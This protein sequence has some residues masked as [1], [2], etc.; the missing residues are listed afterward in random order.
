MT[1][2]TGKSFIGALLAKALHDHTESRILVMC[3]TNHA[4][5]QF[6]EDLLDI[7]IDP[8]A[9]VRLGSKS[10]QRTE[11]LGLFKQ[12]S[13]FSRSTTT[14]N[15]INA[16]ESDGDDHID[17][18]NSAF[19]VYRNLTADAT[20]ILD[21]LE[22][23][24]PEYFEAFVVPEDQNGMAIV[25]KKGKVIGKDYLYDRW[26]KGKTPGVCSHLVPPHCQG[27]W[28]LD[29]KARDQKN[30]SWKQGLLREQAESLGVRMMLLDKCSKRLSTIWGE[31]NREI[32]KTK[33]IIGCTTTAA[34]MYSE[35]IRHA[36]PEIVLLEEAGEILESHVLTAMGPETK[37]LILIGDHQQLR[38]KINGYGLSVEKGDGYDL[39]VSLFERLINAGF[40]HTTLLK[41]H[42]MCP[43]I[44]GLVRSLTYPALE[45]AEKT[46]N[47]PEPRGLCDRVIF[48][49]HKNFEAIFK[50]VSDQRDEGSKGSKRN[51]FEAEIVLKIVKYLGQQG[52]GTDKLV[53]LTPYLGQL[54]LLKETLSKQND[55]VL[56]D[57]DSYDLLKA[58]LLSQASAKHSKRQLKLS[59]IDN[60]QGEESEIVIASLTRSNKE[61]DIGFMAAPERL[62]VLLSRARNVLI[63]VGNS[64]TFVSSRKGRNTWKPLIDQLK[65]DGHLYDGLPVRCEQ[66]PQT[67]NIL[68]TAVDFDK[69]CPEG[70]CS[71]PCDVT[72]KC[73]VHK[74][75]SRC[76]QLVDHSQMPCTK[77]VK[78][79]CPRGH[80]SSLPCSQSKGHCRFCIQEDAVKER[81]R[82]RDLKLETERQRKQERY[83]QQIAEAQDEASHLRRLRKDESDD[84]ER[85]RVLEQHHQEIEDLKA[86]RKTPDMVKIPKGEES[87]ASTSSSFI[88][89]TNDRPTADN[90]DTK[91]HIAKSDK[92]PVMPKQ[93]NSPANDDWNDQ[94]K[95]QN[96]QSQEIDKLME[97]IG[98]ESVKDK[99]L[100]IKFKVETAIRQNRSLN[101]ER[102]GSVLLGN[103]GTGKTTVARLYAKFLASMGVIPGDNFIETSGSR[104]AN[105]GVS[106]CQ[107]TIESLLKGGGGAFF[108]DEAYQLVQ[109]SSLGGPQVLDFLLA[110][111]EKLRGKIV[112]ILAGY[113]RPMEKF[114]AHNPGLPERFPHELKFDDFDDTELMQILVNCIEKSYKQKMNVEGGLGGLYC[115]IVARRIG[116]GR[117]RDGFAN[118][119]A[120]ENTLSKITER[121]SE[122]IRQAKRQGART[123]DFFFA[124]A[125][126]IGPDPSKALKTSNAWL[127]LQSMIGLGTVKKTV[128]ALIETM[129]HNF[130]R[131]IDEKPLVEYSLNKVFLGNPGT[132]KTSIAKIYGQILVDIGFLSSGEV[133]LKNPSDFVG[134]VIG[135][136]EKTTKGILAST[137]G[138]V[139]VIDEA[140][141]LYTGGA[142]NRTGAASDPYRAAVVDTIVAEVQ[143]T[144]G[145]DRC[146]LLLG[147]KDLM[148]QMFQNVN[149]GL[150]R[151]FPIDQAFEFK[152][153]TKDEMNSILT[154]KLN[155][156]AFDITDRGRRV[157]L[158]MLER[159]RNRPHFGNA[160]EIDNLLN[161]A[162]MRYQKRLSFNRQPAHV[163]DAALDAQ[164]FDEDFD[165]ADK[166]Q[167]SVAK[168]FEEVVGCETI[169]S[170]LEGYQQMVKKLR[171]L[172]M[173]P[174]DQVPFNFVF[175][176]P[177]G[178]GKTSTARKMGQVYYDMSLLSTN[179]VLEA[180]AT[181]LVG[182][183]VG[184]TGPKVQE[185]LE[186]GLGKVL[187]IDE[188]YR[189]AEDGS[190]TK[191]AINEL[192]D[193]MT[194]PKYAQKLIIILA[195][196]DRDINRLMSI[197]PGL[198]SRFPESLQ[199][200]SLSSKDCIMFILKLLS[201]EKK[202]LL[203]KSQVTF[204]ITCLQSPDSDFMEIMAER[205]DTLSQTEGWAN[206]RDVGSLTKTIFGKTIECS[207]GQKMQL[208]KATILEAIDFMIL[209]RTH[210]GD[211]LKSS[212]NA[213]NRQKMN[214]AV[215]TKTLDKPVLSAESRVST[216][217]ETASSKPD[218]AIK[219]L[220]EKSK[221]ITKR[222]FG[223]DDAVWE[224]L[225]KDKAFAEAQDKE[226]LRWQEEEETQ[227]K[228]VLA[229]K[230]AEDKAAKEQI[231]T[232]QKADEDARTHHE[233]ARLQHELERRRQ[234]ALLNELQKKREAQAEAY[235]KEQANQAKL[236]KMGVCVAG[237]RWIQQSGG[238]RC[239]GGSHW[240]S[241]A[242][243]E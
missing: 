128:E 221:A 139:L 189:L 22:F 53:V 30:Q 84:F 211:V 3:Y 102:F 191:D 224:Q 67:T 240:V 143:S 150:S 134:S 94:K 51:V 68:R 44:S 32:L 170:K 168:M 101:E 126:L 160:G 192:V 166:E 163:P 57:L 10:T 47:R 217:K 182:Q 137:L 45:D 98:L 105:E 164:D 36:S 185:L 40:P 222:D 177:P 25:G 106:G 7:G 204:D 196:Y 209:E 63:L 108:I 116:R 110:E 97:M 95:F 181:D 62:N 210:R 141:G 178:T 90:A 202:T 169:V 109:D 78:W 80:E 2:G 72:L 66:H 113:Q 219:P 121:Q 198:T 99:F 1:P 208:N 58:G 184:Q 147:Y 29:E 12:K 213:S 195:G 5:D 4:L 83:A 64:E 149:P 193:C 131:E 20:S 156:Q 183:Y 232:Q 28:S 43:E 239:A 140:Y 157:I 152:D 187:F 6:L 65:Y 21:Y 167:A 216:Q 33:Q 85:A 159:S 38:P 37:H 206:A 71:A 55:P 188:A 220:A 171:Q 61:G 104:L 34:A 76:H 118:A 93:K 129:K 190:F 148:E 145:D 172:N 14:W 241:D 203:E 9:I 81:R 236:R 56:N 218:A 223:V 179:E 235:R 233:Q 115:R 162:K 136:S 100:T 176:G 174:C 243:L 75:T 60:Y 165:R 173:N 69:E 242:Q 201:K 8:S 88:K 186:R 112:F 197:N 15:T 135:E 73:G 238:Y 127:E 86:P 77:I 234:E 175:R 117:G 199:F 13:S 54:S 31:K 237:Y 96:A 161:A 154:L 35:D 16:L 227:Q 27:A 41:Q 200:D 103:P 133:V 151:R 124:G 138:K 120:V 225:T 122:R 46:K 228:A 194:K 24:D 155:K 114:F 74:C 89:Q 91:S 132:G 230:K 52:Y 146:V 23:E 180:S 49:H 59:T 92:P 87:R 39:N 18:L 79:R 111:I 107:K 144:P 19:Q 231:E 205:F 48:F 70:G 229:L 17:D 153:F 123:D 207:N 125:D 215:H 11:P 42:R 50:D 226:Y 142:S 130:Q 212:S 26:V 158:E 82:Q 214:L 119:R